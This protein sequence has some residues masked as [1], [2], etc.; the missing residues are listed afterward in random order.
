MKTFT[1]DDLVAFIKTQPDEREINMEEVRSTQPC[2]CVLVHFGK[3]KLGLEAFLCEYDSMED[4]EGEL[5]AVSSVNRDQ[6]GNGERVGNLVA[7]AASIDARTYG[8]V[9]ALI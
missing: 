3:E 9:K 2:G 1:Y 4:D 5:L 7:H 6:D 8:E